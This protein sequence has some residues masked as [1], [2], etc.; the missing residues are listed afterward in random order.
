MVMLQAVQLR[1]VSSPFSDPYLYPVDLMPQ[2][3][4]TSSRP[5]PKAV[6]KPLGAL[7][8]LLNATLTRALDSK[9]L[10]ALLSPLDATLTINQ[11]ATTPLSNETVADS[12]CLQGSLLW[13]GGCATAL[14]LRGS[15]EFRLGSVQGFH[16][17]VQLSQLIV[18]GR[19]IRRELHRF[20]QIPLRVR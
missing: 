12:T 17:F 18:R 13:F 14:E 20:F 6:S 3:V 9:R 1:V 8:T 10:T 19:I 5:S 11:G 7:L 15:I 2:A 4:P 16:L